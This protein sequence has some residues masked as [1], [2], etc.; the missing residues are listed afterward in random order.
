ME[1]WKIGKEHRRRWKVP[2]NNAV[3][4]RAHETTTHQISDS[5]K[6]K[7][8]VKDVMRQCQE[9]GGSGGDGGGGGGSD[10]NRLLL[11]VVVFGVVHVLSLLK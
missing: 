8:E 4:G 6:L 5:K 7:D 10:S 2:F 9:V 3:K 11:L 1:A